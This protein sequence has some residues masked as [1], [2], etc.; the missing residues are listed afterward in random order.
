MMMLWVYRVEDA[1]LCNG[2]WEECDEG[3]ES[4]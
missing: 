3:E 1:Q 2:E 4:E